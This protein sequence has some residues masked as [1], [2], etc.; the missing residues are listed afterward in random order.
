MHA[1]VNRARLI[2][3]FNGVCTAH[4][5]TSINVGNPFGFGVTSTE[6]TN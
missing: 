3:E 6:V 2:M 1:I 4:R 5:R